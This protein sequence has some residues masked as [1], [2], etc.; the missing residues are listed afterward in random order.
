MWPKPLI[1]KG[2]GHQSHNTPPKKKARKLTTEWFAKR[3]E[4]RYKTCLAR[5]SGK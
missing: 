5:S 4:G 2:F 1:Y 3:V